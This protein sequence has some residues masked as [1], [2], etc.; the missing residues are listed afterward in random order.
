MH[1]SGVQDEG[2]V[3]LLACDPRTFLAMR[4]VQVYKQRTHVVMLPS[5]FCNRL[6]QP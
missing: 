3:S 6:S 4:H 1:Q 5:A 2:T